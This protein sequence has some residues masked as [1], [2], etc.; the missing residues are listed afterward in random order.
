MEM[1]VPLQ[2]IFGTYLAN[3]KLAVSACEPRQTRF[4]EYV[5]RLDRAFALCTE[6]VP[7]VLIRDLGNANEKKDICWSRN[8]DLTGVP[9]S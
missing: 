4:F 2:G 9:R 8:M 6:S 3:W 1:C 7:L 5:N